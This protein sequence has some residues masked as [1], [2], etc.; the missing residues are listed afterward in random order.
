M[1]QKKTKLNVR[2]LGRVRP[3]LSSLSI[4]NMFRGSIVLRSI[5]IPKAVITGI[6]AVIFLYTAVA[7]LVSTTAPWLVRGDTRQQVDYVWQVYNHKLPRFRDGIIYPP[8]IK[9]WGPKKQG[10]AAN[11]PLF[12][13]IHAPFV[14]PLLKQGRWQA[15]IALGRILNILLGVL[16]IFAL[17]WAGWVYGGKRKGIFAVTVPALSVLMFR[18]TRLNTDYAIDV[19]L[20]FLAT[21]SLIINYKLLQHGLQ[22]KYLI[23]VAVLSVLGMAT[24][25]PYIVFLATSILAIVLASVM[26]GSKT[27]KKNFIKGASISTILILLVLLTI[28]WYYYFRN[29]RTSGSWFSASPST[30]TGGRAYRS[31]TDVITSRKLW[32]LIYLNFAASQIASVVI[33]CFSLSGTFNLT[34][35]RFVNFAKDKARLIALSLTILA[36]FGVFATQ[37]KFAVGYGS[38]NFRYILPALLPIGLFLSFG[39]LEFKWT[40]GQ[41]VSMAVLIMGGSTLHS[42]GANSLSVIRSAAAANHIWTGLP[43]VLLG[44]FILGAIILPVS[45]FVLSGRNQTLD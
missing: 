25:A 26:H 3:S 27:M 22:K 42:L 9:I 23:A 1:P 12:Y 24:K 14:G 41:L 29:Y 36:L 44:L 5:K 11:P 30:Y 37:I 13:L 28:G 20:V 32:G 15:A 2:K 17:S 7:G 8:F 33:L 34:K 39:L 19:L 16:C 31:L 4:L 18:F 35:E 10:V 40:R 6:I 21:L 43:M 38:I 45:L